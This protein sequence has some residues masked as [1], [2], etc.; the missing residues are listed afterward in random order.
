MNKYININEYK[1]F[2]YN[3]IKFKF[4]GIIII[5]IF[6]FITFFVLMFI[7]FDIIY[8][9]KY[10]VIKDNNNYYLNCNVTIDDLEKINNNKTIYIEDKK[11]KYKVVKIDNVID[12]NMLLEYNV[13]SLKLE[14]SKF[15][16]ENNII[17]GYII[18]DKQTLI[19]IIFKL[20]FR[21]D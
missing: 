4:I 1:S 3:Y 16:I 18:Y 15:N 6:L 17:S 5:I 10:I 13:I 2:N 14:S 19:N 7:K 9:S 21:K 12:D 20:I 8:S 11:Y